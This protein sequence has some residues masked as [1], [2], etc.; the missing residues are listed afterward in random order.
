[1]SWSVPWAGFGFDFSLKLSHFSGWV[2]AAVAFFAIL[3]SVYAWRA[4]KDTAVRMK[5]YAYLLLSL[6]FVSGAVL[7]D[8]LALM[9]FFWE[10]LLITLFLMIS[11]GGPGSFKT[12]AKA[13]IIVGVADFCLM[14]G[15]ALAAHQAGTLQMSGMHLP[16]DAL[17]TTAFVLLVIG[18]IAKAGAMPFHSWIPDAANDAPVVFMAFFPAAVEKLLGIYFLARVTLDLFALEP[19]S[20]LSQMLMWVGAA[21]I[22]L[23]VMMALIQKDYKRLL[24]YHAISQVGYMIL[25]IGTCLPV[26][27]AGGLFHMINHAT[28]KCCLFLTAGSVERQT[29]TTDLSQLGGLARVMPV[30]FTCFIIA[31]ASI[32]G[33]PPFNGFFS[34]ELVYEA[35][36]ERGFIFY[37]IAAAGSFFTAASFLKLGHAAFLGPRHNDRREVREAP[38]AML[39]P[40][41]VLAGVCVAFGIGHAMVLMKGIAP[42]L[43]SKHLAHAFTGFHLD[44]GLTAATLIILALAFAHHVAFARRNG[45]GI[46]AAD[47]IHHAPVLAGIYAGATKGIFD[48]YQWGKIAVLVIAGCGWLVDRCVDTLYRACGLVSLAGSLAVRR[49]HSGYYVIYIVWSLI[50]SA[51]LLLYLM[52]GAG[53]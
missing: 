23:A 52:K 24:S 42:V 14:G 16:L 25:G 17:G 28:Y 27:I 40:M 18:A 36:R 3:V 49:M 2:L 48:P 34:K 10:G 1:M 53:R 8:N 32:S 29:E 39:A 33:V 35:A 38:V 4:V 5:F 22:I 12:A 47:H 50:G 26:G 51:A 44:A 6:V 43:E 46:R 11:L 30:T 9:L 31:A 37:V 15:I 19:S 45:G 20:P 41:I 13:F 21:T 7:A